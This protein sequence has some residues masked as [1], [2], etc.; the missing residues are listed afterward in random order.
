MVDAEMETA[1]EK[2]AF[3]FN[4]VTIN[5]TTLSHDFHMTVLLIICRSGTGWLTPFYSLSFWMRELQPYKGS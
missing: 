5:T 3:R 1:V 2:L 4:Q